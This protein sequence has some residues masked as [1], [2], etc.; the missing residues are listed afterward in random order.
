MKRKKRD[1]VIII[2]SVI[3]IWMNNRAVSKCDYVAER[4]IK[5]EVAKAIFILEKDEF[6]EKKIRQN[7]FPLEYDFTIHNFDGTKINEIDFDYVIEIQTSTNQFPINCTLIDCNNGI[8]IPLIEG[9][10]PQMS[11]KKFEQES[12]N[13]KLCLQWQEL[14]GELAENV[15]IQ[16]KINAVQ[17]KEE[18]NDEKNDEK[19]SNRRNTIY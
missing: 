6:I 13:F 10:T 17:S 2:I 4:K 15:E 9:K 7:S 3:I 18:K 1:F 12:R 14:E 19:I 5:T 8:E 16:L 11:L